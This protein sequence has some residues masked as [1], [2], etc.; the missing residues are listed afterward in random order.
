M[1]KVCVQ[2]GPFRLCEDGGLFEERMG[3]AFSVVVMGR[4]SLPENGPREME[5]FRERR[6]EEMMRSMVDEFALDGLILVSRSFG[7]TK[8][9][10]GW[11]VIT[12]LMD[13][14]VTFSLAFH[15]QKLWWALK[16]LALNCCNE[17]G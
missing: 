2:A 8:V 6:E 9:A 1:G 16:S 3:S 15:S 7:V 10:S 11:S 4:W 14:P 5:A 12:E 17:L 13:L